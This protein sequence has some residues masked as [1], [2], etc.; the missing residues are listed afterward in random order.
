MDSLR[1][2]LLQI[3]IVERVYN[4]LT[5]LLGD[6]IAPILVSTIITDPVQTK[7]PVGNGA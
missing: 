5:D 7:E 6:I 2:V 3:R 1:N 4:K